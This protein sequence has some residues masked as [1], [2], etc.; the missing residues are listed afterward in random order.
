MANTAL[1]TGASGGIG[2]DL[3]CIHA[4]TGG[5]IVAV[6]RNGES[7]TELKTELESK[8]GIQ[9][10][11]IAMDLAESEAASNLYAKVNDLGVE[12]DILINNAGFGGHGLFHERDWNEDQAMI[13]LNVM[14]L[15]GITHYFVQ[16]MVKRKKGRILNVASTAGF[17]P[18]P[19]QATYYATKAFVRLFFTSNSRRIIQFKHY[20]NGALPGTGGNGIREASGCR[21]RRSI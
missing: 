20:C 13:Q 9:V 3:A 19:L 17:L 18:G 15:A 11:V 1:I 8:H 7:L 5:D 10:T 4:E 16:D 2:R 6:A 12:V 14:T 21:R